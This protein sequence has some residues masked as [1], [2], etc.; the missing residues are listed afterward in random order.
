M[1]W[2]GTVAGDGAREIRFRDA[3]TADVL[4]LDTLSAETDLGP[5]EAPTAG[6]CWARVFREFT[7]ELL[8][9][10]V[11]AC[12]RGVVEDL[13]LAGDLG[14]LSETI[15]PTGGRGEGIG[16]ER[17]GVGC[18]F[19]SADILDIIVWNFPSTWL[20]FSSYACTFSFKAAFSANRTDLSITA[21]VNALVSS[22]MA[23]E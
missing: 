7:D 12:E 5:L 10:V 9:L 18:E 14:D 8:A 6:C 13:T 22:E 11:V 3:T 15:L 2:T 21:C 19:S 20:S 16:I 17:G 1:E 23:L 4:C